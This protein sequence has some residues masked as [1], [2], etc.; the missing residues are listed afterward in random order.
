M[1]KCRIASFLPGEM[2]EKSI[3][4][5]KKFACF[6]RVDS[7]ESSTDLEK[8]HVLLVGLQERVTDALL[9]KAK[10][11]QII[12]SPTTGVDH[13][14]LQ[15]AERREIEVLSLKGEMDFLRTISST[16][17]FTFA[18]ILSL[19]RNIPQA[20]QAVRRLEWEQ[21]PFQGIQLS[22]K[23]LGLIGLGRV[24]NL[25]AGYGRAFGMRVLGYD[26]KRSKNPAVELRS[27]DEVLKNS[28]IVSL[29]VPLQEE[30]VGL[31]G[32]TEFQKMKKGSYFINTARGQIVD[33]ESLLGVLRS[34]QVQGA[35]LDVLENE[36]RFQNGKASPSPLIQ[37][38]K[39]H[40]NLMI[41]PH[42]AGTSSD[43]IS[44]TRDFIVEKI[45]LSWLKRNGVS[46][47]HYENHLFRPIEP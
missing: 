1:R 29:H 6:D 37:Y 15:S 40:S 20:T 11:C 24:G 27:F 23:T 14:D 16:A 41:T 4:L 2:P 33:E 42:I 45:Y 17:E 30:T 43:A 31:M 25:V 26:P 44:A 32:K 34:G 12:A 22:G 18:L 13:I 8:A 5:L 46:G 35:A 38:A 28:D 47:S 10:S 21:R 36:L 7:F 9:G 3:R 39:T 19:I